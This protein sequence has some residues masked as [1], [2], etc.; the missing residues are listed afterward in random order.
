MAPQV[1]GHPIF[2][3][4]AHGRV[5]DHSI[6]RIVCEGDLLF[7]HVVYGKT[8]SRQAHPRTRFRVPRRL[9]AQITSSLLVANLATSRVVDDPDAWTSGSAALLI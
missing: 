8:A 4:L 6:D 3:R 5:V 1:A 2:A 7:V 9:S